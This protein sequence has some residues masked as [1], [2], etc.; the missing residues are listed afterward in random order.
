[1]PRFNAQLLEGVE[2][3]AALVEA[4][5][6]GG[7]GEALNM[8]QSGVS[9]AIARLEARLGIRLFERT[10]RAVRLTDEGRRYHD[11]VMPL[12]AALEDAT[13]ATRGA[14]SAVRGRLRV[15]V[16][17]FISRLLAGPRLA[18]F[19][20]AHPELELEFITRDALGDMVGDGFDLAIRFGHPPSSTLVA[21]KLLESRILT[22]AAPA[23]L[24]RHG[25]PATPQEL[26]SPNHR[27][28]HFRDPLTGR[29]FPWEFHRRR[30]K[31][32]VD[33]PARLTVSDADAYQRLCVAGLG[34]AQM[35]ALAGEPLIA[36]KQ[37]VQLFPD[38]TD[39]RFPLYAFHPSRHHV[40]AKTRALL[41]FVVGLAD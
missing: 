24:A 18:T 22:V 13:H 30:R 6:F 10:T 31:I 15:N 9:R 2:V 27:C 11:Q 37:L 26:A 36:Q 8:S 35:L 38:W 4:R 12:L 5:S 1:M 16:D 21:R 40:P 28:I 34:V 39:E 7:A 14:A 25:P 20:D 32:L 3:M 17:A 23:Y 29:P 41:D 33:V 19:L